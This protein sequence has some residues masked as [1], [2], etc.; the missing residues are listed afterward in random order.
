MHMVCSSAWWLKEF[1][2]ENDDIFIIFI[3]QYVKLRYG[4]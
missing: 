3:N 2:R 4:I 1:H